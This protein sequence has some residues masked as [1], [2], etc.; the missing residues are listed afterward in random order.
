MKVSGACGRRRPR[1]RDDQTP[2]TPLLLVKV[3]H[4]WWHCFGRIGA[5][6]ED[7]LGVGDVLER[8]R[9]S[10]VESQGHHAGGRRGG[11]AEATVIID[12]ACAQHRTCELAEGVNLLIGKPASTENTD[13]VTAVTL[14]DPDKSARDAGQRLL[15]TDRTQR[16]VASLAHQRR[17]QALMAD[18]QVGRSPALLTQSSSIGR[19]FAWYHPNSAVVDA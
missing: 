10:A 9:Q 13:G 3:L 17:G 6:E 18:Q 4:D 1:I 2:T 5:D 15:P 7:H 8:K 14:P 12:V 11:H 19:E 16:F